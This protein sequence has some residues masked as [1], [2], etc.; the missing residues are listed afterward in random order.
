MCRP[1]FDPLTVCARLEVVAGVCPGPGGGAPPSCSVRW[2]GVWEHRT[3]SQPFGVGRGRRRV[4][5]A[6]HA[7]LTAAAAALLLGIAIEDAVSARGERLA[8]VGDLLVGSVWLAVAVV[9]WPQLRT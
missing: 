4:T 9:L 1:L 6:A 5:P 2:H 3:V 7:L 8:A